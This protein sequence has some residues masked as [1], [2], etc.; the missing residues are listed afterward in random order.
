MRVVY[1]LEDFPH[2][3]PRP[4]ATIGNFDGMHLGHQRLMRYLVERAAHIQGTPSVVTFDPH[5]LQVLAPNNAPRQIQTLRQKLATMEALGIELVIVIPFDLKLAQTSARDFAHLILWER[6]GLREIYVG[7][8]FAFGHRR[9]GSFKLLKE[10][11]EEKGFLVDRIRQVQF[12]GSRVSSTAVRQALVSGQVALARRLLGRP[13]SLDGEIVR[14]TAVG[15]GIGIPTANLRVSN[16]LIPRKGVYATMLAVDGRR[17]PS[18]TNI[19]VRP[20]VS[21]GRPDRPVAVEAHLLDFSQDLYGKE[22]ILEFLVRLRDER[23]FPGID[24]LAAQILRDM[25]KSR[26]YF[27]W[28]NRVDPGLLA[29]KAGVPGRLRNAYPINH[30]TL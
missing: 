23:R 14:G 15:A 6:L 5:P 17:H 1:T 28:L 12:R 24:A 11:G 19:G 25:Q 8:N 3:C 4:V 10:V 30:C 26:R 2:D 21:H 18:V 27:A 9:E 7:P 16:E 20:T 22:V 13:F 29:R